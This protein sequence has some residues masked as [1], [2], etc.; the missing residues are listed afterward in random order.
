MD[1]RVRVDAGRTPWHPVDLRCGDGMQHAATHPGVAGLELEKER[2][3]KSE[4]GA[5]PSIDDP[6]RSGWLLSRATSR[7]N[8]PYPTISARRLNHR[9]TVPGDSRLA[10]SGLRLNPTNAEK[11]LC[12]FWAEKSSPDRHLQSI[13]RLRDVPVGG[14]S[15]RS[16]FWP[17][18]MPVTATSWTRKAQ[19]A[20]LTAS[21]LANTCRMGRGSGHLKVQRPTGVNP[22]MKCLTC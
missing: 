18:E 14:Q 22:R 3:Q 16:F 17:V 10:G 8:E 9:F 21:C 13:Q 11:Q 19:A 15:G 4:R 20:G 5:G 6:K 1:S 2:G 12:R 7:P